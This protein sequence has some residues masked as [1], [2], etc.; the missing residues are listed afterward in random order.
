MSCRKM[1]KQNSRADACAN[2]DADK[3]GPCPAIEELGHMTGIIAHS[4]CAEC[5]LQQSI[6]AATNKAGS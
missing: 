2:A 4:T 5:A 1:G 3:H 6:T